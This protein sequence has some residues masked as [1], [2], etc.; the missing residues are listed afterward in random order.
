[1]TEPL[2][3]VT[4]GE[5]LAVIEPMS[6]GSPLES[7]ATLQKSIGGA[8]VNVAVSLARLGHRIGWVGVVGDDPFGRDGIRMLRGEGV[9]VSRV[10]VDGSSATGVYFKE[11]LPLEGLRNYPYRDTSA[12]SRTTYDDV[13]VRYLLSARVLH[14]TGITALISDPGHDVVTRLMKDAQARG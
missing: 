6:V 3:L 8:E 11:V 12:A 10:V 13:D 14:L 1:M 2:E 7:S 5:L 9:D 4:L